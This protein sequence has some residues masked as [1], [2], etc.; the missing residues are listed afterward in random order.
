MNKEKSQVSNK[1][2]NDK[3]KKIIKNEKIKEPIIFKATNVSISTCTVLTNLNSK[4]NLGLLS[5]FI[6]V[7]DQYSPELDNKS[8]G[9]YNLEFYGNCARGDT[10]IDKI[11]DEFNNQATVKF[12]YWGFRS[13]NVKFFANGK[14]QMTGLKYEDE[15][16][17]IANLL[18]DIINNIKIPIKT[19]I[20]SLQKVDKTFDFQLIYDTKSKNVFYYRQFY[21][22]FLTPYE[23]DTDEIY[24]ISDVEKRNTKNSTTNSNTNSNS[25]INTNINNTYKNYNNNCENIIKLNDKNVNFNRKGFVK[26][27]HD[28]YK[29]TIEEEH[30]SFLQENEWYGDNAIKNIITKIEHIKY[31][32]T[33]ELENLLIKSNSLIEIKKNI[34]IIMKKYT[35]FKFTPI[36]KKSKSSC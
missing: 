15:S 13:V 7:H 30:K 20:E 28:T 32:F 1:S 6:A 34:D 24:N 9:I 8:G 17:E 26:N 35:D 18:I 22:R 33:Y 25:S 14:L 31:Y 4:I 5:R 27:I 12:K 19:N 11:K 16:K 36:R 3:S 23:F 29:D 10:L 2:N 21:D